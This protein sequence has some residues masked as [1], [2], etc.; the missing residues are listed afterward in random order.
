MRLNELNARKGTMELLTSDDL[1]VTVEA[2]VI[3][4]GVLA[5]VGRLAEQ[6]NVYVGDFDV[7]LDAGWVAIN[8]DV[9]NP[10]DRAALAAKFLAAAQE[11]LAT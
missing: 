11:L 6:V 1:V 7:T 10:T 3:G 2:N 5:D 4:L 9:A 8:F